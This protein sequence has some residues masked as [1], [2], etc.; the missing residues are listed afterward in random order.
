MTQRVR[1]NFRLEG[2]GVATPETPGITSLEYEFA[3]SRSKRGG[4]AVAEGL[5]WPRIKAADR[6]VD[7]DNA[8]VTNGTFENDL[9]YDT[10]FNGT[11]SPSL[12]ARRRGGD[13]GA[14]KAV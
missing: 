9:Q 3:P 14:F 8:G 7:N 10:E 11:I 4:A 2:H 1:Y 6:F 5:H 12:C 13:R